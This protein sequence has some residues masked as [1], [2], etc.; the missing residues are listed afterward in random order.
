MDFLLDILPVLF[1]V[2]LSSL[3]FTWEEFFFLKIV[4]SIFLCLILSFS[5]LMIIIRLVYSIYYIW[6]KLNILQEFYQN[7]ND[8]LNEKV[9][10]RKTVEFLNS[11]SYKLY[12]FINRK[13]N[14]TIM[15]KLKVNKRFYK[16][17][18]IWLLY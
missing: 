5:F 6:L 15:E 14:F 9:E 11:H 13:Y 3:M 1:Y 2:A 18:F 17:F 10:E 4:C 12:I 16:F 8:R 7:L